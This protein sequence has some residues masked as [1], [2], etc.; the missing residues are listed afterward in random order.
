MYPCPCPCLLTRI[1]TETHGHGHLLSAII[2]GEL[3]QHDLLV[4][5]STSTSMSLFVSVSMDTNMDRDTWTWTFCPPLL[6]EN[7]SNISL[8]DLLDGF[9]FSNSTYV[10]SLYFFTLLF[11]RFVTF[12]VFSIRCFLLFDLLSLF[13]RHFLLLHFVGEPL[14]SV[15]LYKNGKFIAAC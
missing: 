1:W 9:A 4:S 6:V 8:K 7:F 11:R 14:I 3:H 12:S 15:I 13:C 10:V 5:T 2:G